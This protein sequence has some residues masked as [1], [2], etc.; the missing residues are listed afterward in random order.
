MSTHLAPAKA[1]RGSRGPA[2][3]R[4]AKRARAPRC[5]D[6]GSFMFMGGRQPIC[7]ACGCRRIATEDWPW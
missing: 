7:S 2:T 5:H 1:G 6:C 4:K 3:K